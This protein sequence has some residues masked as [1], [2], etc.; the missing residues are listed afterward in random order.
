MALQD[1]ALELAA[2][3]RQPDE[4]EFPILLIANIIMMAISLMINNCPKF[5]R[6]KANSPGFFDR[7]W[8][9]YYVWRACETR[10]NRRQYKDRIYDLLLTK[11][12][13]LDEKE[14]KGFLIDLQEHQI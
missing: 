6:E 13:T 8:V 2:S 1:R 10:E 7:C 9:S 5:S 14:L 12:A 11:G 4:K 3:I